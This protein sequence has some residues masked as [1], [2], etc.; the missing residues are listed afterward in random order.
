M[1][2]VLVVLVQ[3]ACAIGFGVFFSFERRCAGVEQDA[4]ALGTAGAIAAI[5]GY[6]IAVTTR[7]PAFD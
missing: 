2:S 4:Y 1:E 6:V 3:T 5:A 7:A